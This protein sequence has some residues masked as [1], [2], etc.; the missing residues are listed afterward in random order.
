MDPHQQLGALDA[1]ISDGL[2]LQV[3]IT[4]AGNAR[5]A[6]GPPAAVFNWKWAGDRKC[7]AQRGADRPPPAC[8]GCL[9]QFSNPNPQGNP[10]D[11]DNFLNES[12]HDVLL[13]PIPGA[14]S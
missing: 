4:R 5:G 3:R 8:P 7:G 12:V 10:G 2:A 9:D 13:G 14:R 1:L 6:L 11:L